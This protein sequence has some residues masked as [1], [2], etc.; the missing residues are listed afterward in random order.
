LGGESRSFG[1]VMLDRER[2]LE[3]LGDSDGDGKEPGGGG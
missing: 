3:K 2:G 1:L